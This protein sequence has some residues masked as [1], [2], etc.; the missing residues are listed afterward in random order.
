VSSKPISAPPVYSQNRPLKLNKQGARTW[1][2]NFRISSSD[3][4]FKGFKASDQHLGD[5]WDPQG[6]QEA[7]FIS[8]L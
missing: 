6:M 7:Y 3:C 5:E 4:K 1:L 8:F 2:K